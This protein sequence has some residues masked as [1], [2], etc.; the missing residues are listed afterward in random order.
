MS[1]IL[2]LKY[3]YYM[4]SYILYLFFFVSGQII[5]FNVIYILDK[6]LKNQNINK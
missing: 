1:I 4:Y 5:I 6:P 2:Y 3:L